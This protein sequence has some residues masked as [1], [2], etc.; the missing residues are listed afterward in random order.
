M[1]LNLSSL[2]SRKC[3]KFSLPMLCGIEPSYQLVLFRQLKLSNHSFS[4]HTDLWDLETVRMMKR[5]RMR[6]KTRLMKKE[7]KKNRTLRKMKQVVRKS[8]LL[9]TM[10]W[11]NNLLDQMNSLTTPMS[12][13]ILEGIISTTLQLIRKAW[14]SKKSLNMVLTMKVIFEFQQTN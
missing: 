5:K 6:M 14:T 9:R 1:I 10:R 12:S 8:E 7:T 11:C 4:S 2:L 13:I 3:S